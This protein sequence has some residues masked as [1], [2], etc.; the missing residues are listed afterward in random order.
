MAYPKNPDT[1]VLRNSYYPNGLREIDVWNYYQKVKRDILD[2]TKSRD[3]MLG[4]MVDVNKP[5]LRRKGKGQDWIRLTPRN[6]DEV[7]T[8]RTLTVYSSM[9][10]YEKFGVIDIDVTDYDGFPWARKVASDVYDFVMDKMPV[11]RTAQIRYT[12]KTSFHIICNF[13]RKMKTESIRFL[14][15]KFLQGSDLS[16]VYTVGAKKRTAGV[17]NLDLSPNKYRGNYITLHSLSLIGLKCME[18]SYSQVTSF[19]K[20]KA[21][22]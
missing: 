8:G 19:N 4:I 5:V 18:V 20:N 6:Y 3:V 21:R 14:I 2:E 7:I 16:K 13:N 11:V 15:Q 1:I 22:I 12:G 17:P 10:M 9:G